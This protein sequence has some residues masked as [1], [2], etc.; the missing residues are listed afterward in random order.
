MPEIIATTS[1]QTCLKVTP[2]LLSG[3]ND[4]RVSQLPLDA[5]EIY[6]NWRIDGGGIGVTAFTDEAGEPYLG[7]RALD[8]DGNPCGFPIYFRRTRLMADIVV[9]FVSRK[10]VVVFIDME[11]DG[12]GLRVRLN[13]P[14]TM[15]ALGYPRHL[16]ARWG[17]HPPTHRLL[18]YPTGGMTS[19]DHFN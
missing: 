2:H 15:Q 1:R 8:W 12:W 16:S 7:I 3:S 10:P 4:A 6:V 19:R 5:T 11:L 17:G 13:Q 14:T 18:L 9:G